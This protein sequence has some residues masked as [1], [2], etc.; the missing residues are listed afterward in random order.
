[1]HA[2]VAD[3]VRARYRARNLN[4]RNPTTVSIP[5]FIHLGVAGQ[6]TSGPGF[7]HYDTKWNLLATAPSFSRLDHATKF[8]MWMRVRRGAKIVFI[9]DSE[10][11]STD[12]DFTKHKS[13]YFV[14]EEGAILTLPPG[15][16]RA[17]FSITDS[18]AEGGHYFL[19][20]ALEASFAFG[21]RQRIQEIQLAI[22][23]PYCG[24]KL[25]IRE[26]PTAS[27]L[28]ALICM[29]VHALTFEPITEDIS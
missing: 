2:S 25:E 7:S 11:L 23:I 22:K 24:L 21:L 27:Q 17:V 6:A 5:S 3:V 13:I 9:L 19:L 4:I 14:M 12:I 10:V 26:F 29:T 1:M 20:S 8:C 18:L 15:V 16:P 28:A